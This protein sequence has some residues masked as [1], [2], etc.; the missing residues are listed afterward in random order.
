MWI[1]IELFPRKNM[2]ILTDE[3]GDTIIYGRFP[4]AVAASWDL[5]DGKIV[6]I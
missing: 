4:E 2:R 6:K 5:K 3:N 1:V